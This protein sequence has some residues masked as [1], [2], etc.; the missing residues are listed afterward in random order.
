M[1]IN[2]SAKS[3]IGLER[4]NNEDAFLFCSD[5]KEQNWNELTNKYIHVGNF[6]T[7]AV[8]ADGMGG[9]KAGEVASKLALETIKKHFNVKNLNSI[10]SK[11][12]PTFLIES[13][14]LANESI[15]KHVD[16]DPETIGMGTTIVLIW[17]I[18][19]K[20]YIAWCG[21]SR[22][23]VFNPKKGLIKLTK[24]H[25]Y[26]Q[27]LIDKG[28]ISIKES[29]RH[30]DSN[31][32]TRCLGDTEI[33]PEPE[34]IVYDVS[35]NDTFL[36]CSDGLCGYCEDKLIEKKLYQNIGDL[37]ICNKSLLDIALKSGG[38][39]NITILLLSMIENNAMNISVPLTTKIKRLFTV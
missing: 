22:C 14:E 33:S 19:Q 21:D 37:D 35:P 28:Q 3:D 18:G 25:S 26:V 34:I 5:L 11:D 32:I 12:I 27:E 4:A 29:Y 16:S 7:I 24:D 15:I 1:K 13:I 10:H 39:D 9:A 31:I 36:L 6:G 38:F 23:Y 17:L 20:A 2:I 30:P 8:V